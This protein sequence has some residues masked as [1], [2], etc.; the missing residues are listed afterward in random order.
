M[1]RA[2]GNTT[3]ISNQIRMIVL[4]G[5]KVTIR[6]FNTSDVEVQNFD[7]DD[8]AQEY[9]SAAQELLVG[10]RVDSICTGWTK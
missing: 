4:S 2:E 9:Y 6:Y 8:H 5:N 3:I 10:Q 7:S 1:K